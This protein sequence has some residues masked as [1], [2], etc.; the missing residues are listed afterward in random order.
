MV[1]QPDKENEVA[2]C[3]EDNDGS[4]PETTVLVPMG[5]DVAFQISTE[6]LQ[7]ALAVS[8]QP[9]KTEEDDKRKAV[10]VAPV[11]MAEPLPTKLKEAIVVEARLVS[12]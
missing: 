2:F 12:V 4:A 9:F 6:A 11:G 3:C 10:V 1:V 5:I 7:E 8:D